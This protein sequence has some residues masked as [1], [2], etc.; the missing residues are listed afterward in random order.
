MKRRLCFI[1]FS[2]IVTVAA[3]A[4]TGRL[5]TPDRM[6][7]SLITCICQDAR[8]FIWVGTEYG[9]NKFDGYRFKIG[10]AHV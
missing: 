3:V 6:S 2:F 1:I 4:D 9:L 8:G 5:I 7:S 10:R